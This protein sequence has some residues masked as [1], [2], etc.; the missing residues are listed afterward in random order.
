MAS[1][2]PTR[3]FSSRVENYVKY[4]PDY[5]AG[6][7]DVMRDTCGFAPDAAVADI[8]SGT[9]IFSEL[10][11][12]NG[13]RVFGVEPNPEM[14][15]AAERTLAGNPR[16]VS[17]DGTAEATTLP[18]HRV[19]FITA[20]QAFHW[21][22]RDRTRAEFRRILRPDGWVVLIWNVRR[23]DTT[24]FLRDYEALLTEYGTDYAEVRDKHLDLQ[25]VQAFIGSARVTA[26]T[27]EH[28]QWFGFDGL[29]GRLLSSSYAPEAGHP[30]HEPMLQALGALFAAN[31]TGGRV[32][33]DYDTQVYCAQLAAR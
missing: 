14:R 3:R 9:G 32:S 24:P 23:L 2:D 26:R 6:V 25:Q 11:L 7:L 12:R 28:R 1:A 15:A 27:L 29:A 10:L 20:A 30:N 17:V 16:F 19:G 8:G 22:D 5:P 21:F 4:R 13:N 18:D 31:Q 33:F